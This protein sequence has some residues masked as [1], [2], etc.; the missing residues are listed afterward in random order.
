VEFVYAVLLW[1]DEM[2]TRIKVGY[3]IDPNR[4]LRELRTAAPKA[5]FVG[6]WVCRSG[7]HDEERIHEYLEDHLVGGEVYDFDPD[8]LVEIIEGEFYLPKVLQLS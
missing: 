6:I 5:K 4:R 8:D 7:K 2:P 1:P 3:S